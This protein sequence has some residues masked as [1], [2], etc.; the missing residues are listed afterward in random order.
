M[1]NE[2][3]KVTIIAILVAAIFIV[4]VLAI[5]FGIEKSYSAYTKVNVPSGEE[6]TVY[7]SGNDVKK[8]DGGYTAVPGSTITVTAVNQRK[9]FVSM[10]INGTTYNDPVAEITVPTDGDVDISVTTEEPYAEDKGRYFGNPYVLSKEADV[11]A[12]ARILAGT[13]TEDDFR[14]LGAQDKDENDIRYGYYRLGTNL[15]ISSEEF[16]GLGFRGH[17][18]FGGCFDFDGYTVT[19]NLVRTTHVNEEFTFDNSVHTGDYGFFAFAYGDGKNPCLIKN[20]KVQGFIG[21]NTMDNPSTSLDHIDH[22]NAGGVAGTLGKNVVLD[23]IESTVSVSAQSRFADLYLGGVFGICS[24]SVDEW[25]PVRYDG[26]FNDVSGVTHGNN[27]GAIVGSFAGVIQN[28]SI[29]GVT[30]DGEGSMVLANALGEVSASAI[31][32]GFAGVIELGENKTAHMSDPHAIVVKNISIYAENDFSVSAVINNSGSKGKN[33]IDPDNF[34]TNSAAAVAGGVVGIVNR[35]RIGAQPLDD[36]VTL[37]ISAISF[38][39]VSGD[40]GAVTSGDGGRLSISASTQDG[41][42]SGAV[43]A[44]GGIGYIYGDGSNG[45]IGEVSDN[46]DVDYFFHCSVDITAMQNGVG[47]AYAGGMF[48]YNCIRIVNDEGKSL[49]VGI[50]PPDREY[51]VTAAQ[52]ATSTAAP[53][54]TKYYN[55]CAGGYSSRFNTGYSFGNGEFYLGNGRITAYR[56][57]DSS[58]I[59]DVNAGGFVGRI[60]GYGT[61]SGLMTTYNAQGSQSGTVDNIKMYYSDNSRVE[62]SCYSYESVNTTNTLGNNVCAG[63]VFGYVLGYSSISNIS[64]LYDGTLAKA[65]RAAEYF[66]CGT[67]NASNKGNDDDLMTEGFVGGMFGLVIDTKLSNLQLVGDE[68]ENSV[69]YFSSSNSPNTASV[70]GLMG[71]LWR[72]RLAAN[73][74]I[75]DNATVKNVHAAGKAYCDKDNVKDTY[76]IYVGGMAGVFANPNGGNVTIT[77][78]LVDNCVVDAI[79]EKTMLPYAGGV[80]AG[81]WWSGTTNVSYSVV[82]NSAVTASSIAPVAYAG[83]IV[84]LMQKSTVSYCLAQDTDV[85]AVSEQSKAYAGGIAARSKDSDRITYSYSNASLNAKGKD[86]ASSVK[87]G[88]IACTDTIKSTGDAT[89]GASKNFFVYETAGTSAAYPDDTDTRA[90]YLASNFQNKLSLPV[91]G[92]TNVFS[93]VGSAQSGIITV[94]TNDDSVLSVDGTT[95]K[96]VSAGIVYVSA[97]C[98]INGKEYFLCSY[99][100]TVANAAEQGVG[101]TLVTEDGKLA[102]VQKCDEYIDYTHASGTSSVNYTYFRRNVGNPDTVKKVIAVPLNTEYLPQNIRFYD[103]TLD[104]AATYFDE[105]TTAAEKNQ[106]IAAI[107]AA[108]GGSCDISAFNGRVKVGYNYVSGAQEGDAKK[109]VY[110]YANDNTRDNTIVLMEC[111]FDSYTC[112]VIVEFV[113]NRLDSITIEPESGTPPLDTRVVREINPLTGEMDDIT[114]YVYTAGDVVRFGAT[115]GYTYPAPRSYVVETIYGGTGVTEN[116]MVAVKSG[117]T[118]TVTCRDLKN[119]VSTVVVI[120]AKAEVIF[121]FAFSGAD[122]T[123]DRKMVESCEFCYTV[124][125]QPGYGLMPTV[126]VSVNGQTVE[127]VFTDGGLE[128]TFGT[129]TF[130]FTYASTSTEYGYEFTAG[131]DFVDYVAANGNSV[132]FSATYK[133]IYSVVFISN[134]N[135]NDYLP[136]TVAAGEK[137]AEINPEGFAEWTADMIAK[138][139]GYDFKGFYTLNHAGDVSAYGKSFEDMQK[140]GVSTVN[141]TMRFYARWTYNVTVEAPENVKVTSSLSSSMLYDGELVPLDAHNGFGF[142][143]ETSD[144]WQGKP[145]FSAFVRQKDGTYTEITDKFVSASQQNGYFVSSDVLEKVGSGYIYIKVYADSLEFAVGDEPK[146][147]GNALYTDGIFTVTYNVNYG[148]SDLPCDFA[149]NFAPLALPEGTSVRLFYRRDGVAAWAGNYIANTSCL[150][151]KLAD[152]LSMKDGS[153]FDLVRNGA[154]SETFVAVVTLPDNSDKFGLTSQTETVV[155]VKEYNYNA[156]TTDYGTLAPTITDKPVVDGGAEQTFVLCPAVVRTVAANATSLRFVEA[157]KATDGVVDQRHNGMRYMWRI[158]KTSGGYVGNATFNAFGTEY[159]RTTDAVYFVATLNASVSTNGLTGYTVS[160]VAVKNVMQ[161]GEGTVLFSRAF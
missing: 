52:S 14:L 21:I 46:T 153:S 54:G 121:S 116:G 92:T 87:Y 103:I 133:K 27:S 146:Y 12:V 90:L 60:L 40:G 26:A 25:C 97:Y 135:G 66:V 108:K 32:G 3:A 39:G 143:I 63:G 98:N 102:Q 95:V 31:A 157:G 132:E 150:S 124:V 47:P 76:D 77:N 148:A 113:P 123:F 69:V 144:G 18:P 7:V 24:S 100:V 43:F 51:T 104:K 88:I 99:P 29:N 160:L 74:T 23:G 139:Y 22:I 140:D 137:F 93:A 55:V 59:G 115:L 36:S 41:S 145:R 30:I 49:K 75:L 71:A 128:V 158:E 105:T 136:T 161:P 6:V 125:P 48:G 68:T 58:A 17:L 70:G 110:F 109:S 120:E 106:R 62:A 111:D 119:T 81:M 112:G 1:K 38:S 96:G 122:G 67:Q 10:T 131:A 156:L 94:K 89:T 72:R 152:F 44:G 42:S 50:V 61:E 15:F 56:E 155:S 19:I 16:F 138:R 79:G 129:D 127:G 34:K 84:G 85:K 65:G 64:L 78:V 57:V 154:S 73:L 53:S 5:F 118:Y 35:G 151:L 4:S 149:L 37:E 147:D 9:L 83:G 141:G 130:N 80:V 91:N 20:A 8:S 126:T 2:N 142:V 33:N 28:A 45:V 159:V 134:Y 101:L 11:M 117:E 82:K 107:I 114:H 13:S 86:T